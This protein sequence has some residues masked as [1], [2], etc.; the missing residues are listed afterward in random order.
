MDEA[1]WLTYY[2]DN[3]HKRAPSI[4]AAR[5]YYEDTSSEENYRWH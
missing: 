2:Y 1:N 5:R 4:D 3:K